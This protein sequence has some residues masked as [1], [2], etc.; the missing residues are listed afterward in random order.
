MVFKNCGKAVMLALS[1]IAVTTLFAGNESN[2]DAIEHVPLPIEFKSD[3]YS[4]VAFD[5]GSQVFLPVIFEEHV[6]VARLFHHTPGI[7]G[8]GEH[9]HAKPVTGFHEGG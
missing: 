9:I 7:E 5:E 4:P 8:L 6:V 3:I 2:P 1:M